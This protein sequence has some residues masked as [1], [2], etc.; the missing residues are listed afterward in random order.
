MASLLKTNNTRYSVTNE[1]ILNQT[2]FFPP[3]RH[4]T[5]LWSPEFQGLG[6][7][8]AG[9]SHLRTS[10]VIFIGVRFLICKMG[11]NNYSSMRRLTEARHKKPPSTYQALSHYG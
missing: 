5:E 6:A 10:G 4:H 3:E 7:T 1:V 2:K 11:I 9:S 8:S